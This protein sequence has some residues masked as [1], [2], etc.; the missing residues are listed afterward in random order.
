MKEII[1][2]VNNGIVDVDT[3]SLPKNTRIIL[4]DYDVDGMDDRLLK[5]DKNNNMYQKIIFEKK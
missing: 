2:E 1:I 5:K 4:K 3:K